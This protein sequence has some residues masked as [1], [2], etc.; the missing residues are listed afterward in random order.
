MNAYAT[1][2]AEY[3]EERARAHAEQEHLI[4]ELRALGFD[5]MSDQ[6]F[7][8]RVH[9]YSRDE[10]VRRPVGMPRGGR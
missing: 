6:E 3:A 2:A 5:A 10:R 4:S 9:L 7:H 8:A 1:R